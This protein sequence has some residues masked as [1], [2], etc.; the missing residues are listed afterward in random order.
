MAKKKIVDDPV[1]AEVRAIRAKLWK[2]AGGTVE[3]LIALL[4]RERDR[5]SVPTS[6][7]R[8]RSV[9]RKKRSN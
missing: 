2:E 9:S 4:N 5:P 1:V 7:R 3:G 8:R 6:N